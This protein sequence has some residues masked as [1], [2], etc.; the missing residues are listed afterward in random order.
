MSTTTLG[1]KLDE[2]ARE[3]IRRAAQKID[4]TPHWLIKQAIFHYLDMLERSGLPHEYDSSGVTLEAGGAD[5]E[6][7]PPQ[8]FLDLALGVQPQSKLRAAITAAYRRPETE[9]LPHLLGE[10][11]QTPERTA[12]AHR[13]ALA[14]AEQLREKRA[15]SGRDG[16]VQGLLRE[17]DL[18]SQEGVALM[19]LAE[20]LLRIPD[21]GTR[22]ALIRDKVSHADWGAHLRRSESLFVNA[23]TWGL[24]I[25][26]KL[27]GTQSENGLSTALAKLVAKG[28]E[29]V[30]RKGVDMAMRLLGEQFVAGETIAAALA[31]ARAHEAA[32]FRYSYD[33]LGEAA[34]TAADVDRYYSAYEQAIH[35]IGGAASGRG[36]YDGPGISVKLS[37]LHPRYGRAQRERVLAELYPRLFALTLLAR[38]YD[39]G[40]NIDAEEAERLE[41]SLDLL[42]LL[43]KEPQLAGWNGIGCVVQAYQKRAL[44][45]IAFIVDLAR[46]TQRRI[47][48][49]LVKGAYWDS[50]IKRAQVDGLEGY[51]VFTRKVHTDVSYL[52][53]ARQLLA[54]PE[55]VYPQF[56]THNAY[57]VAAVYQMAGMNYYAGQY[58]FQC[59]HGMGEPLYEEIVGAD[60]YN[61]PC[62]IYAPVGSHAT[63]LPY[64]VRRLLENGANTSFINRLGNEK[65]AIETLIADPLAE[66]GALVPLGAPHPAIPL[67]RDL[68]GAVRV[69]SAGLDLSNEQRLASLSAG[70]LASAQQTWHAAPR[71]GNG[72]RGGFAHPV[73]NPADWR[74]GVGRVVDAT[75]RDI[76]DALAQAEAVQPIWRA[77]PPAARA[78]L[79][80]RAA[81]RFEAQRY[82]LIG[83]AVREA[84]K[85]YANAL[86]EVREA[87]D[88]LRFY[89]S[90]I[91]HGFANETHRPL[92]PLACI[93]PWNFP[94]AIFTGQIAAALAA[95]NVVLAKPAE[96]TPLIA[97]E[98]VCLLC[99]A[100]LPAGALQ[101]LPG[102]GESVGAALVKDARVRGVMFT[103]SLEVARLIAASLAERLASDGSPVPLV[104]ETGG[105]NAMIVDSSALLE[106]VVA[107]VLGS[108]FDSAGQRCSALRVL[109]VQEEIAERLI[110]MLKGALAELRI[111][112]PDRL[113]TDIGP[114][115][116]R[117]ARDAITAHIDA[118]KALGHTVHQVLLPA[119]CERGSFVAPCLIEIGSL[120]ELKREVFGPV[121]HVLRYRREMLAG[122]IDEIHA[123]GYGLTLG[124]HTR[125]DETIAAVTARARVGNIYINRNMIGAVV[126]VQPFGGEGLSGTGP[127]AGGPLTLM[128]LVRGNQGL[129]DLGKSV[130]TA[131]LQVRGALAGIEAE[132][133]RCRREAAELLD[134]LAQWGVAGSPE[135]AWA[136]DLAENPPVGRLHVLPGPTGETNVHALLPRGRV[137]CLG[138][139]AERLAAQLVAVVASGNRAAIPGTPENRHA[140]EDLPAPLARQIDWI[141]DIA[142]AEADAVLFAGDA[143]PLGTLQRQLAQAAGKLIACHIPDSAGRYPIERLLTERVIST[144]TAAAGGNASLMM[145]G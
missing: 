79:L 68:Y 16:L 96:Q 100:G 102:P 56:A 103:G 42:E 49:R 106:Q 69:N 142:T 125:I 123:T 81:E 45:A 67:P 104:A 118:M 54:A 86:G 132:T 37:A 82:A 101:L 85:T 41:L 30:V 87:V 36:I 134:L 143:E 19:C 40:L 94:L 35:A 93:S 127:K 43:C 21:A 89:A 91:R 60:T 18:S 107:D 13:M 121:L 66:A 44:A 113:A 28:G 78:A 108:A 34:L 88:F 15:G 2:A 98:A 73:V 120:A 20:A 105:Q 138:G 130:S 80:E 23:T 83:L 109:C 99:E 29:P 92:G 135:Q 111:G 116:E 12:A 126:G 1:V 139:E 58:E 3:R 27:V 7:E 77:T 10:A 11:R 53:C 59:L 52:A 75:E 70:L 137:L 141:L 115:I 124:L 84:G 63:L 31:H 71:L 97:A 38:Q 32:G 46:R 64:L 128:R 5:S 50:E 72:L 117:G 39:I 26:G 14:L 133:L 33:M 145:V 62:R 140:L 17:F 65:I 22:D 57:T 90:E 76:A 110:E 95:G 47:M 74:D 61:R 119:E 131:G 55:A 122:L 136:R 112:Q 144:N 6:H 25:T 4:R 48:V 8:P 9:C 24:L 129:R 114:V 51:P